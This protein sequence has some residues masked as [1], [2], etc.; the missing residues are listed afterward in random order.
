MATT[1][2]DAPKVRHDEAAFRYELLESGMVVGFA[3]YVDNGDR[4][5]FTYTEV[6]PN[7]RGGGLGRHLVEAALDDTRRSGLTA[8]P[9]CSFVKAVMES[10]PQA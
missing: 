1:P 3:E 8:Y 5:T 6:D 7:R 9:Q 10:D 4:R 2:A